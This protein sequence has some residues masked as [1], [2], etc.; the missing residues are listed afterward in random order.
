MDR[1][2]F[3]V[4]AAAVGANMVLDPG[5]PAGT[6]FQADFLIALDPPSSGV[7]VFEPHVAIDPKNPDRIAVAAQYGIRGG[8][9]GGTFS[10][11]SPRMAVGSGS[12]GGS[13]DRSSMVSSRR[14]PSWA[15]TRTGTC[16]SP[17]TL[18]GNGLPT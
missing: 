3:V 15:S 12:P 1:R 8:R 6:R 9:G 16:S 5:K 13:P 4:G 2:A 11:G 10:S 7:S 14:T 18:R 17:A